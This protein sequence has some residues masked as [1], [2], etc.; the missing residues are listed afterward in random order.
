MGAVRFPAVKCAAAFEADGLLRFAEHI[1][2]SYNFKAAIP[3]DKLVKF[4]RENNI[5]V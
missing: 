1:Q 4:L 2:G 5:L 3:V